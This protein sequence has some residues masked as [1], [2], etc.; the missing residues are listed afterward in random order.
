MNHPVRLNK[1]LAELGY[2]SRRSCDALIEQGKVT[3]NSK[4]AELGQRVAPQDK[5]EVQ[6]KSV[7]QKPVEKIVIAFNKPAGVTTTKKDPFAKVT[8]MHYLPPEFQHLY[9]I[10]R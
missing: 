1:V 8:V 2:G 10:G 6:G 7:T 3:V 9:P 4:P 5:I